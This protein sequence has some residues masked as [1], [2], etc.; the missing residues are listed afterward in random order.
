MMNDS[1][2]TYILAAN[3]DEKHLENSKFELENSWILLS[4]KRVGTLY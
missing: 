2:F 1:Y 4:S 3:Y